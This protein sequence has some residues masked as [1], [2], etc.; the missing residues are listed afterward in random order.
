[1]STV[2]VSSQ[3]SVVAAIL[4]AFAAQSYPVNVIVANATRDKSVLPVVGGIIEPAHDAARSGHYPEIIIALASAA[5]LEKLAHNVKRLCA[6]LPNVSDQFVITTTVLDVSAW[7]QTY[8]TGSGWYGS[9]F[10]G[11]NELPA[12]AAFGA[13]T[14]Q[15]GSDVYVSNGTTWSLLD[16]DHAGRAITASATAEKADAN[17]LIKA[18][19]ADAVVVTIPND[20]TGLWAQNEKL[21]IYQAG[22]GLTSFA[23]GDGVTLNSPAGLAANVQYG[24][25]SAMRVGANEWTLLL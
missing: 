20:A 23:A 8:K 22:A 4:A 6:R 9:T 21:S 14:V 19:S 5:D 25:I 10:T 18:T 17:T 13:G 11:L 2:T 15:V 16:S 12:A 7:S 1:M 3:S 24:V